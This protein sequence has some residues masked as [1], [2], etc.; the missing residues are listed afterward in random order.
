MKEYI[1]KLYKN[2]KETYFKEMD[3]WLR[4]GNKKIIVTVNP[5]TLML[6]EKNDNLKKLMDSKCVSLVPLS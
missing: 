2:S 3:L 1:N 4:G 6:S 5:E